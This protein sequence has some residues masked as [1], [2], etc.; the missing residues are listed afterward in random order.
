[1]AVWC[2]R[3]LRKWQL[4]WIIMRMAVV[5]IFQSQN[6][7]RMDIDHGILLLQKSVDLYML[8]CISRTQLESQP[9]TRYLNLFK[10]NHLSKV[11]FAIVYLSPSNTPVSSSFIISVSFPI[12]CNISSTVDI[13]SKNI[14]KEWNYVWVLDPENRSP[15]C[16]TSLNTAVMSFIA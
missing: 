14:T 5:Q 16:I 6:R 15:K 1:M 13:A 8:V 4:P 7:I 10:S 11:G 2:H 12:L 3:P 9:Q